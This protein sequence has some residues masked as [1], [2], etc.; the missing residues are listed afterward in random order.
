MNLEQI[1]DTIIEKIGRETIDK[2]IEDKEGNLKEIQTLSVAEIVKK[3]YLITIKQVC[4]EIRKFAY[5]TYKE[6]GVFD[7]SDLEHILDQIERGWGR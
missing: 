5:D 6:W 2:F 4:D 3:V 7:E 1:Q